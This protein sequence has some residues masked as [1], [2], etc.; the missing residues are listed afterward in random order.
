[1][2]SK[3]KSRIFVVC[4][5]DSAMWEGTYAMLSFRSFSDCFTIG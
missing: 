5:E 1:M 4:T 2:Q 3:H